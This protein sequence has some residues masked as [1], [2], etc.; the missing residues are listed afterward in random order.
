M[1]IKVSEFE[2]TYCKVFLDIFYNEYFQKLI[3]QLPLDNK[4]HQNIDQ[5]KK[6]YS[7]IKEYTD[8]QYNLIRLDYVCT[9][10][11]YNQLYRL[12]G[13]NN[14]TKLLFTHYEEFKKI[15]ERI[16]NKNLYLN[17]FDYIITQIDSKLH[18]SKYYEAIE[19][20]YKLLYLMFRYNNG[21]IIIYDPK[22]YE[23]AID[24]IIKD[25]LPEK[26][27]KLRQKR[28]YNRELSFHST[29]YYNMSYA[30]YCIDKWSCNQ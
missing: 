2:F 16:K 4:I 28:N 24:K 7:I 29:E 5:S 1:N 3:A 8:Y 25:N 12:D 23:T 21:T 15:L 30:S 14:I 19:N 22:L 13:F 18:D 9:I 11:E 10:I 6:I 17:N 26:I 20:W 27:Y